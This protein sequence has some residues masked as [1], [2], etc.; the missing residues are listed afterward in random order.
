MEKMKTG[1]CI[2]I[3]VLLSVLAVICFFSG[4]YNPVHFVMCAMLG[5]LSGVIYKKW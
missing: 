4:F 3:T 1:S 5:G 2:L